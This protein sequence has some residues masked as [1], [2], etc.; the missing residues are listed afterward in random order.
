MSSRPTFDPL[1]RSKAATLALHYSSVHRYGIELTEFIES[2]HP[3]ADLVE[4][5]EARAYVNFHKD[6]D[7][8][9][10]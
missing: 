9:Q 1:P 8:W 4:R 10:P 5:Q 3:T 7:T 6:I 2:L